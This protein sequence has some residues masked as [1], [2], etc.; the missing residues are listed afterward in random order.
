MHA[1]NSATSLRPL[2][3]QI[4]ISLMMSL[5]TGSNIG[6]PMYRPSLSLECP[7]FCLSRGC[8]SLALAPQI[9]ILVI[10]ASTKEMVEHTA[11]PNNPQSDPSDTNELL[12]RW[13]KHGECSS[14]CKRQQRGPVPAMG[15][16]L[17][18]LHV[19]EEGCSWL[20]AWDRHHREPTF[21]S[22]PW[23]RR[24]QGRWA[25][26]TRVCGLFR[27]IYSIA[28]L[29]SALCPWEMRVNYNWMSE[30]TPLPTVIIWTEGCQQGKVGRAVRGLGGLLCN[31]AFCQK[32]CPPPRLLRWWRLQYLSSPSLWVLLS[33]QEAKPL[34]TAFPTPSLTHL[35]GGCQV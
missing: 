7:V 28:F 30:L 24:C 13:G 26:Q 34:Q 15:P 9:R 6:Q 5:P 18:H 16:V 10:M 2:L 19:Q 11:L 31:L 23:A 35:K 8:L 32:W 25:L 12:R 1:K 17:H 4:I 21:S 3:S 27:C 22:N 20:R 29:C 33:L 14:A